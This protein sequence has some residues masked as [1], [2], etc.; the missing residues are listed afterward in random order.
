M[1]FWDLAKGVVKG[2]IDGAADLARNTN[3]FDK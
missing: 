2:F 3:I 1:G